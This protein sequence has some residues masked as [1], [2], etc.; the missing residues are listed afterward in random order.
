MGKDDTKGRDA[1][2]TI[3]SDALAVSFDTHIGH[4]Y[5]NDYEERYESLPQE[6]R[7]DR[8]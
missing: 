1:I 6:G 5:L 4:D 3:L 7:Q 2:P 8:I